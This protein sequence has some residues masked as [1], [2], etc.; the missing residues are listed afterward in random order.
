MLTTNSFGVRVS[1]LVLCDKSS[2]VAA[3]LVG[4]EGGPVGAL[5]G[6]GNDDAVKT[7]GT[8]IQV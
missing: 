1:L 6:V 4:L 7:L 8:V 5:D 3:K 2:L